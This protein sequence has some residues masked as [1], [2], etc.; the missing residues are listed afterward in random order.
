MAVATGNAAIFSVRTPPP[1]SFVSDWC[2]SRL[3]MTPVCGQAAGELMDNGEDVLPAS[4]SPDGAIHARRIK[5]V[6]NWPPTIGDAPRLGEISLDVRF[7]VHSY[8][9][10][11]A[12]VCVTRREAIVPRGASSKWDH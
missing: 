8:C 2:T 4:L 5:P 6:R 10:G 1:N 7:E 12:V 3:L 11:L 9:S